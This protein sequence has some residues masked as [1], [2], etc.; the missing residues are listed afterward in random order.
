VTRRSKTGQVDHRGD[1]PRPAA[2]DRARSPAGGPP[3]AAGASGR[4]ARPR[5]RRR[6]RAPPRPRVAPRARSDAWVGPRLRP[7]NGAPFL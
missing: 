4:C 1:P 3:A 6:R 2:C 5:R 7:H